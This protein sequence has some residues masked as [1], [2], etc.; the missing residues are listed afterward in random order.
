MVGIISIGRVMSSAEKLGEESH[1][2]DAETGHAGTD[3]ADVDFDCGP[4]GNG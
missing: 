1:K 4:L 3:D 2:K